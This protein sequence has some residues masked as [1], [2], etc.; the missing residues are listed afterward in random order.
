MSPYQII[1]CFAY[2]IVLTI[3]SFF[4]IAF[5]VKSGSGWLGVGSCLLFL[6]ALTVVE[7]AVK[8]KPPQKEE[9]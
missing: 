7:D 8:A 4:G 3:A 1:G 6:I 5:A 9:E 2:G